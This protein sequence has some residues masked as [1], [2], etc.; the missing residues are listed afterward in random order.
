M[1]RNVAVHGT[2]V[3]MQSGVVELPYAAHAYQVIGDAVVI[4][5][6]SNN[7]SPTHSHEAETSIISIPSD[8]RNVMALS[9]KGEHLWTAPESP[10]SS[11][12]GDIY[13]EIFFV[14]DRLLV[15][16]QDGHLYHLSIETGDIIGSWPI[17]CLPISDREMDI[18]GPI[19]D[20]VHTDDLIIVRVTGVEWSESDTYAFEKDGSLRWR[21]EETCRNL[22]LEDGV[23][24]A[25]EPAGGR[26]WERA[27]IDLQTGV[28]DD[29]EAFEGYP[30]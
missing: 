2:E 12:V 28:K 5:V 13:R 8:S 17:D 27:P 29:S 20:I 3:H 6:S 9:L 21:S 16:H 26:M 7:E 19:K 23:L 25:I 1:T 11:S 4:S 30:N 18:D 24:W 10:H 14:T 22:K 15:T